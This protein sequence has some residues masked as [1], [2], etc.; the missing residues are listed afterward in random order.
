MLCTTQ[1]LTLEEN[2]RKEGAEEAGV[3]AA[4]AAKATSTGCLAFMTAKSDGSCMKQSLYFVWDL[5]VPSSWK[6]MAVDGEV[7]AFKLFSLKALEHEVRSDLGLLRPS[8]RSVITD[9]LIRHGAISPD[10][11]PDYINIVAALH[12]EKLVLVP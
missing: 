6:P 12:R 11:E 7:A 8:M 5:E 3:D 9:F 4:L 10:S 2:V 1:G